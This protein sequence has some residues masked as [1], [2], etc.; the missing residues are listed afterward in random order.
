MTPLGMEQMLSLGAQL[1]SSYYDLLGDWM[2]FP[3]YEPSPV[4]ALATNK[5]RTIGSAAAF[6]TAFLPDRDFSRAETVP[7]I[8]EPDRETTIWRKYRKCGKSAKLLRNQREH[9]RRAFKPEARAY[10]STVGETWD[11]LG[12]ITD[13]ADVMWVH[14]CHGIPLTFTEKTASQ[15]SSE[16]QNEFCMLFAGGEGGREAGA[17]GWYPI[18]NDVVMSQLFKAARQ[19]EDYKKV[20][21]LS[22]HGHYIAGLMTALGLFRTPETCEMPPFSS[23]L[24]FELWKKGDEFYVRIYYN[25]KL[26]SGFLGDKDN[27]GLAKFEDLNDD[28]QKILHGKTWQEACDEEVA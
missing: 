16:A 18:L 12:D 19:E 20:T 22:L 5:Q 14:Y 3:S 2:R 1:H 25:G 26:Q 28:L 24:A 17:L 21:L 6:L 13:F 10:Q 27:S 23:R 7:I 8:V 4:V 15:I 11:E 9:V